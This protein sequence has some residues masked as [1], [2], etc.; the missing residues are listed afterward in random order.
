MSELQ[1]LYHSRRENRCDG[2]RGRKGSGGMAF[3]CGTGVGGP[4]PRLSCGHTRGAGSFRQPY[5]SGAE[6]PR[7]EARGKCE[8]IYPDQ[9]LEV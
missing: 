9:R 5:A 2:Q 6:V 1:L 3:Q 8:D 7:D 4:Q